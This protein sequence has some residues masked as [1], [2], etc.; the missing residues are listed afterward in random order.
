MNPRWLASLL[1]AVACSGCSNGLDGFVWEV[2]LTGATDTCND[3]T[4][5]YRETFD[6]VV[7][8]SSPP[9]VSVGIGDTVFALG[10][11]AGD[12]IEYSSVIWTDTRDNGE[13]RWQLTGE[14][15]FRTGG[16]TGTLPD[17]IDWEGEETFEI[18]DSSVAGIEIGCTYV[19]EAEG[20][21]EGET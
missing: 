9:D 11:L 6:Y 18:V 19:M 14:A 20:T 4:V 2:T 13:L 5:P 12:R 21:Y 7:D 17:G 3:P 8:L 15:R 1:L 16:T 10:S